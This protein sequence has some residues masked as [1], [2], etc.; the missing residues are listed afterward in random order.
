MATSESRIRALRIAAFDACVGAPGRGRYLGAGEIE[1][2]LS[3]LFPLVPV[4]CEGPFSEAVLYEYTGGTT[5]LGGRHVREGVEDLLPI[6]ANMA[7]HPMPEVPCRR[8]RFP[9]IQHRIL[10]FPPP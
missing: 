4:L 7:N 8:Y 5:V 3:D 2:R 10:L 6:P 9:R 1:E